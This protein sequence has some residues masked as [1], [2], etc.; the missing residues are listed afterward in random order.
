MTKEIQGKRRHI[1]GSHTT[2]G[3]PYRNVDGAGTGDFRSL[4]RGDWG[5]G[6]IY[7]ADD[8]VENDGASYYCKGAHTSG[9][10]TEPGVGVNWTAFWEV[11]AAAGTPGPAGA[12]GADGTDG[13][14]GA[15]WIPLPRNPIGSDGVDDDLFLNTGNGEF[16]KKISG[17]WVLQGNLTGAQGPTGPTGPAGS[18]GDDGATWHTGSGAPSGGTG[19]D[20]DLYLDT[21]GNGNYYLKI[22]GTWVFQGSLKGPA[23]TN[24]TNGSDG[25]D[26]SQI[27][28]GSGAPSSGL[29]V[30]GDFYL[31]SVS[32]N[33]YLKESGSWTQEGNLK[34]PAGAD[35]SG[36]LGVGTI[37]A[38]IDNLGGI[39]NP[40]SMSSAWRM[41]N[42]LTISAPGSP[43]NGVASP[44]LSFKF[45]L[46]STG[47]TGSTGGSQTHFH[48]LCTGG[49]CTFAPNPNQFYP[50]TNI[51]TQN[52]SSMPP[53]YQVQW[54]LK[55]LP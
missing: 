4:F 54:W 8:V 24:G 50:I 15:T 38:F 53:Y 7:Y 40:Y 3:L 39:S 21:S 25:A 2:Q 29:G 35:G 45:L 55:V 13:T 19:V 26:G 5:S 49:L 22:S 37:V 10:T 36:D 32:G 16:W 43:W 11:V 20:G 12:D 47:S 46:G 41:C 18:N 31:D 27:H 1:T 30:D 51:N 48:G 6:Q 33:Y 9:T 14:D 42:G 23:G 52:A 44:A 34:G 17:T 28:T